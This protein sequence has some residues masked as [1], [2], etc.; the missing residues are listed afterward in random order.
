MMTSCHDEPTLLSYS[1]KDLYPSSGV[2][3]ESYKIWT[4]AGCEY[5][6]YGVGYGQMMSHMGTCKNPIHRQ[7]VHDT[8]VVDANIEHSK[9]R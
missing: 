1:N 2:N 8:V 4:I 3:Y 6:V 7:I 5:I 9:I